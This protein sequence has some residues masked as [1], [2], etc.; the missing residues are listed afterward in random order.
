MQ[1]QEQYN[2][3]ELLIFKSR[4]DF[5]LFSDIFVTKRGNILEIEYLQTSWISYFIFIILMIA[6]HWT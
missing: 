3:P 5:L 6:F 1:Q 2:D 4:I